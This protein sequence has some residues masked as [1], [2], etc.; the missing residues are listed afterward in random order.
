MLSSKRLLLSLA[1]AFSTLLCPLLASAQNVDSQ[2]SKQ[3]SASQRVRSFA[4][5]CL[6]SF[7][8]VP[9]DEI[10]SR[11][12]KKG[13]LPLVEKPYDQAKVD[14]IKTEIIE[15]YKDYGIAVGADSSFEPTR[16]LLAVRILIEVYKQ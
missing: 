14:L 7:E 8:R 6:G 4:V 9:P 16:D 3:T 5:K 2:Q 1:L 15:I 10:E 13:L 11:L 12:Q